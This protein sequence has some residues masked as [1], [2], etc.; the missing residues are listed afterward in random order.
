MAGVY[1]DR[2]T[3]LGSINSSGEM[4]NEKGDYLG[5]IHK[6]GGIYDYHG[7]YLGSIWGN[8]YIYLDGHYV[9]LIDESGHVYRDG[10]YVGHI[11]GYHGAGATDIKSAAVS[12]SPSS[13]YKENSS[14]RGV[15]LPSVSDLPGSDSGMGCAIWA[16]I[17]LCGITLVIAVVLSAIIIAA[18][19]VVIAAAVYGLS[20]LVKYIIDKVTDGKFDQNPH[21]KK[22]AIAISAVII[23]GAIGILN[24]TG[25][26]DALFMTTSNSSE[27]VEYEKDGTEKE[28]AEVEADPNDILGYANGHWRDSD[29]GAWI[30]YYPEREYIEF[31]YDEID[32]QSFDIINLIEVLNKENAINCGFSDYELSNWDIEEYHYYQMHL[33]DNNSNSK[34]IHM[35]QSIYI[36]QGSFEWYDPQTQQIYSFGVQLSDDL[37]SFLDGVWVS[38]DGG[39]EMTYNKNDDSMY[40]ASNY[41]STPIQIDSDGMS[42]T[43]YDTVDGSEFESALGIDPEETYVEYDLAF[44]GVGDEGEEVGGFWIIY[45]PKGFSSDKIY[46][47]SYAGDEGSEDVVI[48]LIKSNSE[49]VEGGSKYENSNISDEDPWASYELPVRKLYYDPDNIMSGNDVRYIQFVLL[50]WDILLPEENGDVSGVFDEETKAAVMQYQED[51]GLEVDGIVGSETL[52]QMQMDFEAI[53]GTG[54][55]DY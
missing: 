14:S 55:D 42:F 29:T 38:S 51:A 19:L 18:V 20:F 6:D 47:V 11:D 41:F 2:E 24:E 49:N 15:S 26:L 22:I 17:I 1:D 33:S 50:K 31:G 34:E 9:G 25:V 52:A 32:E 54:S 43:E 8:G 7:D 39:T 44:E 37:Y 4:Y 46:L 48:E 3:Y 12:A 28:Q 53:T 5:S 21:A 45:V 40:I 27:I 35:F 30:H 23:I 36:T 13:S 10:T 16:G